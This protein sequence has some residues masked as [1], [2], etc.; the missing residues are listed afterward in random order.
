M[1]VWNP[2]KAVT[3]FET[4]GLTGTNAALAVYW[5]SLW[6]PTA[7][8]Q[9]CLFNPARV[10]D[11]LPAIGLSDVREDSAVCRLSGH[12]IDM[13]MGGR[14]RGEDMFSLVSGEQRRLRKE[15]LSALVRGRVALSRTR[16]MVCGITYVAETLQLPFFGKTE[17][18]ARQYLAHTNWRPAPREAYVRENQLR[19]GMPDEYLFASLV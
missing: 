18:G 13:A 7:P 1:A 19:P 3:A 15:R 5:M 2:T 10:R 9:R 6:S 16:Y 14:L 11:L 12:Y 17:E 4:F 8:P